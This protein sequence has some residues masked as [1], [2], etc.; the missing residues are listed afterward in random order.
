VALFLDHSHVDYARALP[1]ASN[2]RRLGFLPPGANE[3]PEPPDLSDEAFARRDV[4]LMFTG[5]YRGAPATP[6][7]DWPDSPAKALVME[8]AERMAADARL[9]VIGALKEVLKRM[10]APLSPQFLHDAAPLIAGVQSFAEAYHR[11]AA[12]G[13]IGRAGLPLHVW[14]GGWEPLI[15][16]H[17]SFVYGGIGSF[18]ETL[19][20]LRRARVVLNLNNGF[21]AGGHER[22][23]TAMCAGAAVFSD[24]SRFYQQAFEEGREIATFAWRELA[25][26]PDALGELAADVDR[27][28]ALARAGAVRAQA[29]H[30]WIHRAEVL[31]A[32]VAEA[33]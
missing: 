2:F 10:G 32:A 24:T 27:A 8:M 30:R 18:A 14:G 1:S 29:E 7:R 16:R 21:V 33:R 11:D 9:P 15:E 19:H 26:A 17:P 12:L 25:A 3:L 22:V 28:S 31:A 13:A 4:P 20:T 23:F 5:T 6:W